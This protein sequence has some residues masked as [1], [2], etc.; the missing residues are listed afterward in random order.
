MSVLTTAHQAAS[1]TSQTKL[2]TLSCKNGRDVDQ[3]I[4]QSEHTEKH[5]KSQEPVRANIVIVTHRIGLAVI[6]YDCATYRS[7]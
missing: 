2:S 1:A 4:I 6:S 3:V 7:R 5:N